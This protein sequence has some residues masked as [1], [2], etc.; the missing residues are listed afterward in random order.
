MKIIKKV[1][2]KR[3][4][5][6]EI[7]YNHLFYFLGGYRILNYNNRASEHLASTLLICYMGL[8]SVTATHK[9]LIEAC[10]R[11][12]NSHYLEVPENLMIKVIDKLYDIESKQALTSQT[13]K[14]HLD[15]IMKEKFLYGE[16]LK[17]QITKVNLARQKDIS[18]RPN[19]VCIELWE[20]L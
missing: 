16:T 14:L 12:L 19:N 4:K 8:P 2:K 13:I 11:L 9:Q 10:G 1:Y 7:P 3:V 20:A 5:K 18:T 15:Q 17:L 6:K